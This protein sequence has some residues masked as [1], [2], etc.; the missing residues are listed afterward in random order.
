MMYSVV[1][2]AYNEERN[3]SSTLKKTRRFMEEHDI[4]YEIIV[5][6]DGSSDRTAGI[7]DE[8]IREKSTAR[9]KM[10]NLGAKSGKGNA[11]RNGVK[12]ALGDYIFFTD[13]DLPYSVE[14]FSDAIACFRDKKADIIV[15]SRYSKGSAMEYGILRRI[16]SRLF[17]NLVQLVLSFKIPDAQCGFKAFKKAIAKDLFEKLTITGFAF[18][19]ELLY[20]AKKRGLKILCIPVSMRKLDESSINLFLDSI[21]MI[22][23]LFRIRVNDLKGRYS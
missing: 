21:K 23:D 6:N 9:I 11:V 7:V 22:I 3:I 15:G 2:P 13:A 16:A 14:A 17:S 8:I 12:A 19:D 10:V 4:D 5:V 20:M 1:I 18:D